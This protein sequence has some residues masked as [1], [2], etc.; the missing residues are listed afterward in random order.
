MIH[1]YTSGL[2]PRFI[3]TPK[4]LYLYYLHR[5]DRNVTTLTSAGE[6]EL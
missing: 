3:Y 2:E 1:L 6:L 4:P 5:Y